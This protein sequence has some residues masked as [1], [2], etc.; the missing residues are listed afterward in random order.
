MNVLPTVP[1]DLPLLQILNTFQEGRSHMAIVCRRKPGYNPII[2]SSSKSFA[3]GSVEKKVDVEST[4]EKGEVT[5]ERSI[6]KGLF[7][8]KMSLFGGGSDDQETEEK[9]SPLKKSWLSGDKTSSRASLNA[10]YLEEDYP[11]GLITL[12]DVLEGNSSS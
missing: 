4:M 5:G 8:G 2:K 10:L 7:H 3:S 11:I 1:E 9:G 12:E 6:L